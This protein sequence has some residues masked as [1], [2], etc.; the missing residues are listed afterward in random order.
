MVAH[1]SDFG[2]AKLL[3]TSNRNFCNQSSTRGIK[4]TIG[5]A[6]PE[7]GESSQ[8]S[9]KGDVYSFGILILEMLTGRQPT[10]EMFKDGYNLHNYVK[11]AFPNNILQIVDTTLLL[12]ENGYPTITLVK[13]NRLSE[14]SNHLHPNVMK[15]LLSLFWIGLACSADSPRERMDMMEV[16]RELSMIRNAF[17]VEGLKMPP[18][19]EIL[20]CVNF[21]LQDMAN[22]PKHENQQATSSTPS[23]QVGSDPST[24]GL[25]DSL[26][27]QYLKIKEHAETYPY[28]WASY[29]VVYG[30]FALWTAYRWRK[31]RKT[32]DRVRTLQERLRKLV[33]EEESAKSTKVVE[34]GSTSSDKP[35]K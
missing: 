22:Q 16:I 14:K 2:L 25:K 30:G 11:I 20:S 34:K 32:E 19:E 15:C 13:A 6:P 1:V 27:K 33:E 28:V 29:I 8:V 17:Y 5:Y 10:E 12:M 21:P 18:M 3:S 4:G 24:M 35:S 9:T 26:E 23:D 7:Y 31:L